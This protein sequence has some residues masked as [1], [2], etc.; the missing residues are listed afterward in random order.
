MAK[1]LVVEDHNATRVTLTR[2]LSK[3]GHQVV[4]VPT[5]YD[6]VEKLRQEDFDLVLLDF[7]MKGM[8]GI[9]TFEQMKTIRKDLPYIMVTA[10]AHSGLV[11]EF[12]GEGGA[13]FIVKPFGED[14]EER[15]DH[16]LARFYGTAA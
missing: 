16:N 3:N 9:H 5:G 6:G 15:I 10:Y 11:K 1:I 14:F 4:T 8:N 2:R 13:D 12:M 7:M